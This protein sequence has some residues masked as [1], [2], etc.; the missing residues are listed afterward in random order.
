MRVTNLKKK[1]K[2]HEKYIKDLESK[3]DNKKGDCQIPL[4]EKNN[5]ENNAETVNIIDKNSINLPILSLK[6]K[7]MLSKIPVDNI[8]SFL[9]KN[10]DDNEQI[11]IHELAK[12]LSRNP[13]SFNSKNAL[14]LSRYIIEPRT[15]NK[16]EYNELLESEITSII[17]EITNLLPKYSLNCI[18]N[19]KPIQE[20][21][22]EKLKN[23]LEP[24]AESLQESSD[25]NGN[26]SF[27]SLQTLYKKLDLKL[28][29]DEADYVLL[30]M[31]KGEN[32]IEALHYEDFI[33]HLGELLSTLGVNAE[34]DEHNTE[35]IN[36]GNIKINDE[37][38]NNMTEE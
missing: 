9:F 1:G 25:D 7:M 22:I 28:T 5:K 17:K 31:Y 14:A 38:I 16:I 19:P 32:N 21:L 30:T 27:E 2:E 36:N 18:T 23:K 34:S 29:D 6:L 26:I 37:S 4:K 3:L 33:E 35:E 13:I 11:S 15:N 24:F 10:F 8:K 20:S 12:I